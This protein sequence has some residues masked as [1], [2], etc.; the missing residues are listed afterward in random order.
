MSGEQALTSYLGFPLLLKGEF[1]E[2]TRG[3]RAR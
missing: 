2:I 1:G 3:S